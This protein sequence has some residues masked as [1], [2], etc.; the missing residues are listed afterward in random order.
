M[1]SKIQK[2]HPV[3]HA[4]VSL[5]DIAPRFF[6]ALIMLVVLLWTAGAQ[7]ATY[8]LSWFTIDGG[9]GTSTGGVYSI[10]GTIGQ[11]DADTA[12]GGPYNLIGGFWSVL[13]I[14]QTGLPTLVIKPAGTNV[15]L[16]WSTN[17]TG[18]VLQVSLGLASTGWADA[19]SGTNNPVTV[20]ATGLTR[21]YRLR[22]Q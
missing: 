18:F 13:A 14:Q 22:R 10:S 15:I 12:A 6:Q 9:G 21:F 11:P 3:K 5:S 17:I 7:S 20:T 1:K 19:S 4:I 16:S 2:S 8:D